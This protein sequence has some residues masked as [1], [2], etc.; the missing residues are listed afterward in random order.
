[1]NILW[2]QMTHLNK[3]TNLCQLPIKIYLQIL[4]SC[5]LS[6]NM[7]SLA[8]QINLPSSHF[9]LIILNY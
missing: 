7:N 8:I 5:I 2:R 1:M 6:C 4:G 3:H 9:L